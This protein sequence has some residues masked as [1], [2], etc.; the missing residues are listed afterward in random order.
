MSTTRSCDD[1]MLLRPRFRGIP[2]LVA[3][4]VFA[5][6]VV[7]LVQTTYDAPSAPAFFAYAACLMGLFVVSALYHT[8][9]WPPRIR[10][11]WKAVDHI[12]IYV[13]IAGSYMPLCAAL[14]E[15][16]ARPL[17]ACMW[18]VAALG[19]GKTLLWPHA[20][21]VLTT[22][23]YVLMGITIIPFVPMMLEK[24]TFAQKAWLLLGGALYI[25]GAVV[26]A[27]KRPDP[28]P[29]TFGW[30][31]VFHLFVIAAAASHFACMMSLA[32]ALS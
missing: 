20:P 12:M 7:V 9:N 15:H 24:V 17:R 28:A 22:T 10:D 13:M 14:P 1:D 23:I 18:T 26:Y 32:Q 27:R 30:H 2:D 31:E 25:A 8:F 19:V 4:A 6:M 3:V 21:R 29:R 11:R 16:T 5:P